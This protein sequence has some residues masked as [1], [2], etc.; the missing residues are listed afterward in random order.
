MQIKVN[1]LGHRWKNCQTGCLVGRPS[2]V[3]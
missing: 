3:L 2:T 1:R